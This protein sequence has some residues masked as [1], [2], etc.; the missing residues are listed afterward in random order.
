M[1]FLGE[2]MT[3]DEKFVEDEREKLIESLQEKVEEDARR[4]KNVYKSFDELKKRYSTA[5]KENEDLRCEDT[6]AKSIHEEELQKAWDWSN[7]LNEKL[8]NLRD[9]N[10]KHQ[11]EI[12]ELNKSLNR[13]KDMYQNERNEARKS[14]A[15]LC[16]LLHLIRK[17]FEDT[18]FDDMYR[19]VNTIEYHIKE[20]VGY[21]NLK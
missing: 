8:G 5:S 17:E 13:V 9:A 3:S 19:L 1:F 6:V 12:G 21:D 4:I 7:K 14:T 11:T 18:D 20:H 15:F 2:P 16:S 10:Y